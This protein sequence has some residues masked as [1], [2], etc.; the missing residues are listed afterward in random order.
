MLFNI[1][2][3]TL[4]IFTFS[5]NE[6]IN[7]PNDFQMDLTLQPFQGFLF[8]TH[9]KIGEFIF[10]SLL[11]TVYILSLGCSGYNNYRE[12]EMRRKKISGFSIRFLHN[13]INAD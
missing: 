13:E 7:S 9:L 1:G 3:C 8:E 5:T 11:S 10:S 2:R 12:L 6:K 4:I